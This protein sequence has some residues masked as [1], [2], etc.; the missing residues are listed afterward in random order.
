M[1]KSKSKT[2]SEDTPVDPVKFYLKD[3]RKAPLLT[4]DREIQ[5]SQQIENSKQTIIDTLFAV[6]ISVKTV[7]SWID[8]IKENEI[9]VSDVFD[10][11]AESEAVSTQEFKDQ[12]DKARNLCDTYLNDNS[13]K[14]QL[15]EMFNEL[16]L[17]T[18]SLNKLV[19]QV[20]DI[21][22]KLIVCDGNMLRV[23]TECGIDRVEFIN[24]YV[25]NEHMQWLDQQT[26][27]QWIKFKT[28]REQDI[29]RITNEIKSYTLQAGL[30]VQSF[31]KM[32]KIIKTQ[33]NLKD[34]AIQE[35]VVSNLRLVVSIAKKYSQ[36]NQANILDLIQEG[37]IGLMKAVEKFKWQLGYRFSTYATWWIRQGII[38]AMG[39]Q[40]K[41]IRIPG[42]V[43]DAIKKIKI[44]SKDYVATHGIEPSPEQISGLVNISPEKIVQFLQ[45]S[46]ETISLDKPTN[47]NSEGSIGDFIQDENSEKV[48][49]TLNAADT[50]RMIGNVLKT[51]DSREERVLRMRFGIGTKNEYTL[52]EIGQEFNVTRERIRQIES[53]A[54]TKLRHPSRIRELAKAFEEF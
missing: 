54:L 9:L 41:T 39:E 33:H 44:A 22:Q 43:L 26:S 52:E 45:I 6:P 47:D 21:N 1:I 20:S 42:H 51:L 17:N 2:T 38:K 27:A 50:S 49:E 14:P 29:A 23:A 12:L 37:N 36:N 25:G 24:H 31:R 34:A 10:V 40:N 7:S 35:M 11:D 15:V 28:T 5:L 53:K 18:I 30:D 8:A 16:T 13:Y 32:V 46:M 3:V 19:E 4:H 48:I